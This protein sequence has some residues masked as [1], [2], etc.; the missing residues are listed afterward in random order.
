MTL[1][2]LV[3]RGLVRGLPR[4]LLDRPPRISASTPRGRAVMGYLHANCG[5]CHDSVGP[6]SSLGVGLRHALDAR[7]E[8]EEPVAAGFGRSTR[9]RIPGAPPGASAWIAPGAPASSAVLA[10]MASRSPILQMP[11]LGTQLVDEEAVALVRSWIEQDLPSPDPPS[12]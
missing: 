6:M 2:A 1:P 9:F 12:K 5:N 8:G 7:A 4:Q 3:Q 11:P 10:R